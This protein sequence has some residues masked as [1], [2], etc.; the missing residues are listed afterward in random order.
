MLTP[1]EETSGGYR[2]A[3]HNAVNARVSF[4]AASLRVGTKLG[5]SAARFRDGAAELRNTRHPLVTVAGGARDGSAQG[6]AA[7]GG[8]GQLARHRRQGRRSPLGEV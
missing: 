3:F 1:L 8:S 4:N 2:W 6:C 7:G 5:A